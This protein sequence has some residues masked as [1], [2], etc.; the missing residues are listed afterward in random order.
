MRYDENVKHHSR[1]LDST[2]L[3]GTQLSRVVLNFQQFSVG[4]NGATGLEKYNNSK[5]L[6]K[7][8]QTR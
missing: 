2:V 8:R 4:T 5:M 7:H 6:L 1:P 3:S